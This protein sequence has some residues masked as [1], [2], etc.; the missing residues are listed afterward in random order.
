MF[1][2]FFLKK[3]KRIQIRERSYCDVGL[4]VWGISVFLVWL[5][6]WQ[7]LW[8]LRHRKSFLLGYREWEGRQ[9]KTELPERKMHRLTIRVLFIDV[10]TGAQIWE[11]TLL[12]IIEMRQSMCSHS[13]MMKRRKERDMVQKLAQAYDS[14][15]RDGCVGTS[16]T[17]SPESAPCV[18]TLREHAEPL[19][20]TG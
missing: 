9:N 19:R 15:Q 4:F 20:V 8:A 5:P 2:V 6:L 1:K 12:M 14:K 3:R 18:S 17:R 16:T 11:I 10:L 13:T 7:I